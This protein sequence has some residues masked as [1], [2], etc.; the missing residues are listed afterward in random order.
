MRIRLT[1]LLT[2]LLLSACGDDGVGVPQPV[3]IPK[4]FL[5]RGSIGGP[6]STIRMVGLPGAV[7]RAGDVILDGGAGEILARST[8]LGSFMADVPYASGGIKIR[9]ETSEA[10]TYTVKTSVIMFIDTI[11][12]DLENAPISP[13]VAG[14]TTIMG[15]TTADRE[16]FALNLRSAEVALGASDGA[17]HF[18]LELPA[19]T[20]D[21]VMVYVNNDPLGDAWALVV[22]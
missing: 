12:E 22:P 7:A 2:L 11:G 14:K 18:T 13:V 4:E 5:M 8:A 16:V 19:Q 17:G 20:G 3:P 10:I 21:A 9:L 6:G 1:P 15:L